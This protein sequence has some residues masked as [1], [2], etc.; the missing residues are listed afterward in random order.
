MISFDVKCTYPLLFFFSARN[1][2]PLGIE[3]RKIPRRAITA[4]S[5]F[6]RNHGTDRARLNT[7]KQGSKRGAWSAKRNNRR[8]WLQVDLGRRT[9]VTKILT[10]GRQDLRQWVKTYYV[11][12]SNDGRR[13][14]KYRVLKMAIDL[15]LFQIFI[16]NSDRNTVVIRK[17]KPAISAR[18]VRIV[19]RTWYKHIS[20]RIELYG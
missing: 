9:V 5:S 4:S 1:S 6:D 2:V 14:R 13:F 3:D 17:L 19:P 10:Q 11:L 15:C 12:Y 7:V 18:F 16:G 8:Q 20:M